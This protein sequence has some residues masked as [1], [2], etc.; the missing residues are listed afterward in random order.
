VSTRIRVALVEQGVSAA[1][2]QR[3]TGITEGTWYARMRREDSWR[4]R[5]LRLVAR[6]L[7]MRVS[8]LVDVD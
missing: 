3:A 2:V 5:E 7:G 4:L 6:E 8:E 1:S